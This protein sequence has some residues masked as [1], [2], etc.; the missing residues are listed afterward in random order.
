[1]KKLFK[2]ALAQ[3]IVVM[4][5]AV[6]ITILAA[7]SMMA[8]F[9][10]E[11]N[12]DDYMPAEHPA[13]VFSDEADE[14]FMIRDAIL[15]A[16]EHP[17][18]IYNPDSLTKII[19]IG[20]DLQ[21]IEELSESRI[22]SV[23]T[24]D[25]ILG[26]EEGLDVR[27]FY[28]DAP[29]DQEEADRIG[30]LVRAN[31]M[32]AGRLVSADERTALIIIDL[33]DSGF[34][35]SLYNKVLALADSYSGPETVHVAGRPIIEGT[36]A[37]LGPED[38]KR[39]GPLVILVILAVLILVLKQ[40]RRAIITLVV[41]L[42]STIWAFGLMASMGIP[43]YSISVMIPVM[44]IAIGVAYAIHLYNQIDHYTKEHPGTSR[45][46]IAENAISVIGSPALFAALTTVAGF[47]SLVTSQVY[48][49][50]YFGLFT[51]FGVFMSYILTML[52]V[53]AGIMAFGNGKVRTR[54]SESKAMEPGFGAR[55]ATAVS[56]HP[57]VVYSLTAILVALSLWGVSLVWINTSFLANFEKSSDIVQT[58]AFVNRNFGG[59]SSFNIILDSEDSD[60]FKEPEVLRLIDE[61]QTGALELPR[62]GDALSLTTYIRRM[63]YSM[64][65]DDPA[66]D[67][68]PD[69]SDMV[70]QYLLLYEMS[71]DPENLWK[72][73]DTDYK[74]ANVTIQLK[75]DDTLTIK[76]VVDYVDTWADEFA[77][78]GISVRY[79]G[80][81]YKSLVFSDLILQG[82]ISSLGLSVLIVFALVAFL[83]R[84]VLLGAIATIP[85]LISIMVNFG[86]MGL[87]GV[88]LTISTAIISSIAVGIGVDYAIHF[89]TQYREAYK[90]FGT[91]E[92]AARFAMG[93]TGRAISLNAAIVISGFMVMIFSVFP[94]NRQIGLLVSLN[95]ITALVA[96]IT[97][98]FLVMRKVSN[99]ILKE[100]TL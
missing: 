62:V 39:T 25:N 28:S 43:L 60:T 14:R 57:R 48:P 2:V 22:Q 65:A 47:I 49:V 21:D 91:E 80:S 51:A 9:R 77:E 92:Q 75:S 4:V 3:P 32:I 26:T 19:Q 72:V 31:D 33:P 41:V 37:V 79:A 87:L 8:D 27:R 89:I 66:Y 76:A 35:Q 15:I 1:M 94:P 5:L 58:D 13:F 54:P 98:M 18:S 44:L 83:F 11:T 42:F 16:L 84:S 30:A 64:N 24:G 23:Y 45:R 73:V 81:G 34:S 7:T 86:L 71:G 50:K 46:D 90:N 82:Q 29:A 68:I 17:D 59:T 85:I 56:A 55:F 67:T 69:S 53:P 38:M 70:A 36:L 95:M 63:H 96:T 93:H 20:E 99:R 100:K 52:L 61:M 6:A 88:P 78:L 40:V 74:G 97:I 12:L 10:M